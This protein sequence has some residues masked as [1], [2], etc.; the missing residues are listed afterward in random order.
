MSI[1]IEQKVGS[2]RVLQL[3]HRKST[4]PFSE[5]L[6]DG[7]KAALA[8]AE[9]DD[10]VRAVVVTGGISRSFSAGGDFN[11]VKNLTGGA[12]VDRWIDRVMDLY[13]AALKV[14]KPT[15]AAIDG[16]AVGMGFQF[17]M[18]FDWR[19]MAEG[20]EFH[21]PELKHGIGCSVGGAILSNVLS[22]NATR[23]II[24]ECEGIDAARALHYGLVDEVVPQAELMAR[25]LSVAEKMGN[26]PEVAFRNTKKSVVENLRQVLCRTA[27]ESKQVHRAAFAARAMQTH[28]QRILGDGA[29]AENVAL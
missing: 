25:A 17:A 3:N 11:E 4:N 19:V 15:I 22:L 29:Y 6:E 2:T 28:F 16:F 24:F 9:D 10:S 23:Q 26:Y 27:E 1:V 20:A 21:M 18:M 14:N 13:T 7:I 8:R 12:D 5:E